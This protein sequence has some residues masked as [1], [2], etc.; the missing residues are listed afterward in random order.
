MKRKLLL[1]LLCTVLTVPMMG[2]C[3]QNSSHSVNEDSVV[4]NEDDITGVIPEEVKKKLTEVL[5]Q[6]PVAVPADGWT[7]AELLDVIYIN[8]EKMN[9]PFTMVDLGEG[10][11]LLTDE[12][13]FIQQEGETSAVI[14]YYEMPCGLV[15]ALTDASPENFAEQVFSGI[16]FYTVPANANQYPDMFPIS[17][18]GITIG[19]SYDDIVEQLGFTVDEN[20]E[21]P[22]VSNE[23]FVVTGYTESYYVR[24][25]GFDAT[26]NHITLGLRTSE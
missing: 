22:N 26:I 2:G 9:I 17:I 13:N 7:D 12:E 16:T 6:E 11:S 4:Q 20:Q 5:E 15:K 19:S 21:D 1:A 3:G 10:Y 14:T 25:I 18:N 23:S 8:G 24:I